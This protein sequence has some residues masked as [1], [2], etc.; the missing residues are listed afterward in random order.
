MSSLKQA[1]F[2]AELEESVLFDTQT[3][4]DDDAD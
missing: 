4:T 3:G 1:A 2:V